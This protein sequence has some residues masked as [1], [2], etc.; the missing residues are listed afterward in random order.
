MIYDGEKIGS[1]MR[2]I[3]ALH[4]DESDPFSVTARPLADQMG[5]GA[6]L[7]YAEAASGIIVSIFILIMSVVLWNTSLM[8][9][10]RRYGEVGVRLAIGE[11]KTHI[12]VSMLL[13]SVVIGIAGS[14]IGTAVALIFAWYLQTYGVDMTSF[15]NNAS[16]MMNDRVRAQITGGSYVI[17]FIPGIG[18]TLIGTM[19]A[20]V[21][22]YKRQTASLFKELEV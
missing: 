10:I 2:E 18:A 20:G 9:G 17:G 6:Y 11:T 1:L 7:G 13:E 8:G 14:V 12:Y 4:R 16:I 3:N 5:L 21:A 15:M 22:I 19:I